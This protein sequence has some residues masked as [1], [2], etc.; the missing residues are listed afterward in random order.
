MTYV[1]RRYV[2]CELPTEKEQKTM[3]LWAKVL[4]GAGVLMIIAA[5]IV[6]GIGATH[7]TVNPDANLVDYL[8]DIGFQAFFF[9]GVLTGSSAVWLYSNSKDT[10][11]DPKALPVNLDLFQTSRAYTYGTIGIV[12]ITFLLY[13]ILW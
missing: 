9:F 5:A 2:K 13:V 7:T 4:G 10:V 12:T 6:C 3:L 11:A 1:D 8:N